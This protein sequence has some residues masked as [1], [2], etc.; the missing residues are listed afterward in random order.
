M[1]EKS[2]S[3]RVIECRANIFAAWYCG[4][5]SKYESMATCNSTFLSHDWHNLTR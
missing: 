2:V 3:K 4:V 1:N 5:L